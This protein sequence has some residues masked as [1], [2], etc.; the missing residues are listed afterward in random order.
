MSKKK[1]F[2]IL[3]LIILSIFLIIYK[4]KNTY[5][6]PNLPPLSNSEIKTLSSEEYIEDFDYMFKTLKQYYPYFDVNTTLNGLDF[7]KYYDMYKNKVTNCKN[8]LEFINTLTSILN[9][10]HNGHTNI[11]KRDFALMAYVSYYNF[12][13]EDWRYKMTTVFER[14]S[15]RNRYNITSESL[16]NSVE[17]ISNPSTSLE[18]NANAEDIVKGK[19]GYISINEFIAADRQNKNFLED[20]STIDNYLE[21]VK[22][23]ETLI[24]DIRGNHGGD[25]SYWSKYL[26][27]KILKK[28]TETRVYTFCKSGPLFENITSSMSSVENLNNFNFPD[29]TK[30]YLKNFQFY[31]NMTSVV[32]LSKDNINFKG[33]IYL[34]VDKV[35]YSSAEKLASFCKETKCATLIGQKT[36]GDGIGTDPFI[37]DLP[38]SGLLIRFPKEMGITKSGSI[39]ELDKTTPD[40]KVN[41]A[42]NIVFSENSVHY[43]ND[44]CIKKVLELENIK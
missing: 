44:Q 9:E 42:K 32:N 24:I 16:K 7:L 30:N 12:P 25:S 1:N 26:L 23:Y 6:I 28:P 29:N 40:Y 17:K 21:N 5:K 36:G 34:L 31:S 22:N 27:P 14:E 4:N 35:V 41:S 37:F 33:N 11:L 18:K 8:D 3:S 15:V 20:K 2:I 43:E 38:N 19:V 13:K 10:L 39:N